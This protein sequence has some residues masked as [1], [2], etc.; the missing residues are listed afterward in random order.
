[1]KKLLFITL[2]LFSLCFSSTH[3]QAAAANARI[4]HTLTGTGD[5]VLQG[6]PILGNSSCTGL[7]NP[8]GCCT[9]SG[10]GTCIALVNGDIAFV[11]EADGDEFN[12]IF[13][14]AATNA[15]AAPWYIRPSDYSSSGVWKLN[16]SQTF[17]PSS[18]PCIVLRDSDAAAGPGDEHAKICL[19]LT[20]TGDGT[21]DAD[22]VISVF[23]NGTSTEV[24]RIDASAG[25][26]TGW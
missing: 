1:M 21:E 18:D 15:T 19:E 26:I 25:V 2:A 7:N 4:Y 8:G 12:Y 16:S 14:S 23:V 20:D 13:L 5:G 17:M 6:T 11:R 10:T 9:G 24:F 3:V 22:L